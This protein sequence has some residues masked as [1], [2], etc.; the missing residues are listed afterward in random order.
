G[1]TAA[2]QAEGADAVAAA[3]DLLNNIDHEPLVAVGVSVT[4]FVDAPRQVLLQSSV[5]PGGEPVDLRPITDAA[6]GRRVVL[7]N[8]LQ[9]LATQWLLTHEAEAHEDIL[10]VF[11]R[12]GA[13]GAAVLIGG[14]PYR[15]CVMGGN[16]LGHTR[17]PLDT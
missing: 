10:L 9:A 6:A 13:I 12:D 14:R 11:V 15:G 5:A 4:G 17:L 16:E 2:R 3:V 8:D 1:P 7:E